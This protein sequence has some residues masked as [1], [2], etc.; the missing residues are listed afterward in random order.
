MIQGGKK[1]YGIYTEGIYPNY[2]INSL[3]EHLRTSMQTTQLKQNRA[4][5][6]FVTL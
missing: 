5:W 4:F 2:S 3:P 6:M 1:G